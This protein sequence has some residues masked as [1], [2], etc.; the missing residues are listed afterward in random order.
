MHAFG[1]YFEFLNGGIEDELE[2]LEY[3]GSTTAR[4]WSEEDEEF[5]SYRIEFE[6]TE[7]VEFVESARAYDHFLNLRDEG[8]TPEEALEEVDNKKVRN[9]AKEYA[10]WAKGEENANPWYFAAFI[11]DGLES[12][13]SGH[14]PHRYQV[15]GDSPVADSVTALRDM[16]FNIKES[17]LFLQDRR[18]DRPPFEVTCE[19]DIQ[20]LL[21]AVIKPT[22]QTARIEEWTP[23]HATSSKRVDIS[24]PEISSIVETKYVRSSSHSSGIGDELKIDI[25]SYHSHENCSNLFAV[26]WDEN[27]KI[28]D[29][30][31]LE[32]DLTG[33]RSK[34]GDE[35]DV[36]VKVI[37]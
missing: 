22:F 30:S 23:K 16:L 20:D 32:S 8:Y 37:Q 4:F 35:F 33:R 18:E 21:L 26:V 14:K 15:R 28:V 24:I 7:I 10:E 19:N 29:E 36:E 31:N 17:A 12:L 6:P 34:S 11:T 3:D 1:H 2:S 9:R 27:S 25:E 13:L 5:R